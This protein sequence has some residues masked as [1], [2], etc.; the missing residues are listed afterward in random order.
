M[1]YE[2]LFTKQAEKDFEKVEVS[3]YKSKALRLLT[4]L[5]ND[6]YTPPY[7]KLIDLEN[8]YSRRINVQ[9]RLVYRIYEQEKKIVII[10]MWTHYGD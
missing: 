1:N 6:P 3:Q 7:E 4:T 9:H 10:R 5:E 8:T 2:I